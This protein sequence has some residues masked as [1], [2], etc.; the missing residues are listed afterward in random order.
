MKAAYKTAQLDSAG[1]DSAL[2]LLVFTTAGSLPSHMAI[3]Y[4]DTDSV[5][6]FYRLR[7]F[8]DAACSFATTKFLEIGRA[9]QTMRTLCN[10]VPSGRNV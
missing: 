2:L 1:A 9:G 6:T 7:F 10:I 3:Q 4:A 8:D 5:V